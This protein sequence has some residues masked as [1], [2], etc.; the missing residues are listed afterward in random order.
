[1]MVVLYKSFSPVPDFP[2][3]VCLY[4]DTLT[5]ETGFVH[6]FRWGKNGRGNEGMFG[7]MKDRKKKKPVSGTEG[8]E[9]DLVTNNTE[10]IAKTAH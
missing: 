2:C 8:N 6:G 10:K 3:S 1:M 4:T 5:Q 7:Y 9:K